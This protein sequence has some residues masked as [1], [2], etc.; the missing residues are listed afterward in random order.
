MDEDCI[1][2]EIKG[3]KRGSDNGVAK[4]IKLDIAEGVAQWG[5]GPQEQEDNKST[6]LYD[7]PTK[8]GGVGK[9]R[10]PLLTLKPIRG[11]E[12][13]VRKM[14]TEA[15]DTAVSISELTRGA[16]TWVE[17]VE[18]EEEEQASRRSD[19]EERWLWA[20][21]D[22]CDRE[23]AKVEKLNNW[24]KG[25]KIAKARKKM[26]VSSSQPSIQESVARRAASLSTPSTLVATGGPCHHNGGGAPPQQINT[27][28]RGH[29]SQS[30]D[31]NKSKTVNLTPGRPPR[32]APE[33]ATSLEQDQPPR[34]VPVHA[35]DICSMKN[36]V[37]VNDEI[38][39]NMNMKNENDRPGMIDIG[40]SEVMYP[41]NCVRMENSENGP[42][43]LTDLKGD[44]LSTN[45]KKS[46]FKHTPTSNLNF[47]LNSPSSSRKKSTSRPFL[48]TVITPTK[49]KLLEAK[50]V[51]NMIS[52]F[53]M[54]PATDP[55]GSEPIVES[56]AKRRKFNLIAR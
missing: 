32:L 2:A 46:G 6:F 10:Q 3:K 11:A 12:W 41:K 38:I 47:L 30:Y 51:K 13:L 54:Q 15:A 36:E 19:K 45:S 37:E 17:W 22:E 9:M 26:G 34:L 53:E 42:S 35:A 24:K 16:D 8:K 55:S 39:E 1:R 4:R 44:S 18:E 43:G 27:R 52:K 50:T 20:R 48:P 28:A 33:R 56:P 5:E 49:R 40:Q 23:Q 7:P 29:S 14:L 25:K 21:L 31:V